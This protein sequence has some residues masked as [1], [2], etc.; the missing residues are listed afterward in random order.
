M[1]VALT[2]RIV[3][4]EAE[5][6]DCLDQ[7]WTQVLESWGHLPVPIPG[8]LRHPERVL[9]AFRPDVLILTGGGD[10]ASSRDTEATLALLERTERRVVRWCE[11]KRVPVVG[12]CQGMQLLLSVHG[13]HVRDVAGHVARRHVISVLETPFTAGG[14]REVNSF[15]QHGI[16]S[17]EIH[18][19]LVPFAWDADG[20]V[21]GFYRSDADGMLREVGL[22]WHPE[23]DGG[24]EWAS[25][26]LNALLRHVEAQIRARSS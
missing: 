26:V 24:G 6:V 8:G 7:A 20:N 21:E 5:D 15:H 17:Q 3:H 10:L 19:P 12:I 22:M 13:G 25:L 4:S 11:T 23:R 2:Q 18:G 1:R 9:D 16:E 14:M